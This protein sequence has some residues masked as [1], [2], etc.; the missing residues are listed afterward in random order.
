MAKAD[1]QSDARNSETGTIVLRIA[2]CQDPGITPA[3]S[4]NP[5]PRT[6]SSMTGIDVTW[7]KTGDLR[8]CWSTRRGGRTSL[9][10]DMPAA[11]RRLKAVLQ[12]LPPARGRWGHFQL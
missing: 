3:R 4:W 8:P 1:R 5:A 2:G 9:S 11:A 6:L 12:L 7:K 10:M